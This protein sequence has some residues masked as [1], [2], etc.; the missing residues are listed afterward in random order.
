MFEEAFECSFH[1][2]ESWLLENSATSPTNNGQ[3]HSES[4]SGRVGDEGQGR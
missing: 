1:C 3:R 4:E 2:A